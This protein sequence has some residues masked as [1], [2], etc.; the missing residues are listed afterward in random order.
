MK[1]E[2]I[3]IR[4]N[5]DLLNKVRE[6][7]DNQVRPLA[8][9]IEYQLKQSLEVKASYDYYYFNSHEIIE[10]LTSIQKGELDTFNTMSEAT[11]LLKL[12]KEDK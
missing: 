12:I 6:L 2:T 10:F 4:L 9:Q 7:A 1:T 11:R 5:A 3:R 8:K